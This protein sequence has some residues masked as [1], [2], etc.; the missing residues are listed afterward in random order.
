[1]NLCTLSRR[2]RAET[3]TKC[4]NFAP[5]G[6]RRDDRPFSMASNNNN[7]YTTHHGANNNSNNRTTHPFKGLKG[8]RGSALTSACR[9]SFDSDDP[10]LEEIEFNK[11]GPDFHSF[12]ADIDD[13]L[14]EV[15]LQ[16][17]MMYQDDNDT[18]WSRSTIYQYMM[19]NNI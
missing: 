14:D 12:S 18:K 9:N 19:H 3:R 11:R 6:S 16:K 17:F 7:N 1:M 10:E 5:N 4:S 13:N 2:P 15:T 8:S